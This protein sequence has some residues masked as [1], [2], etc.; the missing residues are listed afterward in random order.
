MTANSAK[1]LTEIKKVNK[2]MNTIEKTA[3]QVSRVITTAFS[4]V[5]ASAFVNLGR[6][7]IQ[8]ADQVGKLATRL[9]STAEAISELGYLS[10]LSGVGVNVMNT[11][12]QRMVRRVN[13]AA[14]GNKGY[15]DAL[16]ELNLEASELARM[17]PEDQFEKIAEEM[18]K[19]SNQGDKVRLAMKLFDT[20]G[21]ALIQT[22]SGGAEG[23]RQVREEARKMG[24][25]ITTDAAN[26]AAA[27]NDEM[28]RLNTRM[29]GFTRGAA[30]EFADSMLDVFD[31]LDKAGEVADNFGS[32][33]SI[34]EVTVKGLAFLAG[35]AYYS[36][37][38]LSEAIVGLGIATKEFADGNL[39]RGLDE[40]AI[41]TEKVNKI[42]DEG[43]AFADK[44][45][46]GGDDKEK[47]TGAGGGGGGGLGGGGDNSA[48][49]LQEQISKRIELL[50]TS[51]QNELEVLAEKHTATLEMIDEFEDTKLDNLFVRLSEEKEAIL[52]E[53][54]GR[55]EMEGEK[56]AALQELKNNHEIAM[57]NIEIT[58]NAMRER[59]EIQHGKK[60]A[61]IK[62]AQ[63]AQ[64]KARQASAFRNTFNAAAKSS[65]A[66]FE[67]NKIVQISD[68]LLNAKSAVLGAYA[69]GAKIGGPYVGAAFAAAAAIS[70]AIQIRDIASASFGGGGSA[71]APA[72]NDPVVPEVPGVEELGANSDFEEQS[73][74]KTVYLNVEGIEDALTHEFFRRVSEGL[75]EIQESNVRIVL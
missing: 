24:A 71:S 27:F 73:Q 67:L 43:D 1:V 35:A 45:I 32:D 51:N 28:L 57:T 8:T 64:E 59:Q 22:M 26:S 23:I 72:A 53:Y 63:D 33:F 36:I 60:M 17:A 54:A 11:G 68:A 21:V 62:A 3:K 30:I 49:K 13:E 18:S 15:T 47:A 58:A 52:E 41:A 19:L 48:D 38:A 61:A 16:K 39:S 7:S 34:V 74:A 55:H 6:Q 10:E 66:I 40:I 65:R 2:S 12:L 46:F 5:A 9:G 50:K 42:L 25:T 14:N 31:A 20:E 75:N 70:T 56:Y 37:Q 4:V 29:E 44:L 69:F